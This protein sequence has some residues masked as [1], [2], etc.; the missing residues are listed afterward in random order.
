MNLNEAQDY[1]SRSNAGKVTWDDNVRVQ[2]QNVIDANRGGGGSGSPDYAS[3]ARQQLQLQQEAN[4]P[5]IASL[6][7]SI[8]EIQS[9]TQANV[10]R[11]QAQQAPLEQRYQSL[12]S[13]VTRQGQAQTLG[14]QKATA[15]EFG[16]RGISPLSGIY[17][18]TMNERLAPISQ[19]IANQSTGLGAQRE[20]AIQ[21]L[22]Q[23]ISQ[24]QTSGINTVRDIQ[25]QIAQLQAGGASSGL[26]N[27]LSLYNSQA[28]QA[29]NQ[30][31]QL[32][33]NAKLS[34][35]ITEMNGRRVLM[36][37]QTGQ[38]IQDLGPVTTGTGSSS[39][40]ENE[41][42]AWLNSQTTSNLDT[43]V[44]QTGGIE[45]AMS[46]GLIGPKMYQ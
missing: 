39:S 1:L 2:A 36:N 14:E 25:N 34:T 17:E 38:V 5:A 30:A 26:Q 21:Q 31:A 6:Q 22:Q 3:I 29:Q 28:S 42:N 33:S 7:A 13:E 12:L 8:P 46:A 24:G 4:K 10:A 37:S 15:N 11:L 32:A 35:Q 20:S 40:I 23:L 45:K 19:W 41:L 27:A 43:L 9:Q 18:N 44:K 16:R